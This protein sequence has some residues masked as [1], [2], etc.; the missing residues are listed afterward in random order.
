MIESNPMLQQNLLE[1][2]EQKYKDFQ[3]HPEKNRAMMIRS[4]TNLVLQHTSPQLTHQAPDPLHERAAM[5][6]EVLQYISTMEAKV[7][8]Q[9]QQIVLGCY[10]NPAMQS[11]SSQ[12]PAEQMLWE[13]LDNMQSGHFTWA[14][15][16][17]VSNWSL[18]DF[19]LVILTS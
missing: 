16:I 4:I 10:Q 3:Q 14:S 6:I 8:M 2:L 5:E 9:I 12:S 15:T 11:A 13:Y 1:F 7:N 18:K 17:L 19:E